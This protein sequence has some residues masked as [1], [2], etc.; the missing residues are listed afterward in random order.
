MNLYLA[1]TR[2]CYI[3]PLGWLFLANYSVSSAIAED[4]FT[5]ASPDTSSFSLVAEKK[6]LTLEDA[7]YLVLQH[8]PELAAFD[9]EVR[10]E[11]FLSGIGKASNFTRR[12]HD[13]RYCEAFT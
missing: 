11:A 5:G 7:L 13:K 4:T 2:P 8:N 12:E 6:D 9:K 10:A 1:F 3:L